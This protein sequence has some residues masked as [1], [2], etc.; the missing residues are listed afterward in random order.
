MKEITLE[1][2]LKFCK[3]EASNENSLLDHEKTVLDLNSCRM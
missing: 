2:L 1:N 3:Q